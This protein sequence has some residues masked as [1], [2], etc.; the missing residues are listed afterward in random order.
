MVGLSA[1]VQQTPADDGAINAEGGLNVMKGAEV[2]EEAAVGRLR[3][4]AGYQAA[5]GLYTRVL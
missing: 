4:D 5:V 1:N 2:G 3:S